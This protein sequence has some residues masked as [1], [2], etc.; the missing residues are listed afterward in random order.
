V[1][2]TPSVE[3]DSAAT[4][5]DQ[6]RAGPYRILTIRAPDIVEQAEPGQFVS[7]AVEAAR[8]LLRRPF[9]IA[10]IDMQRHTFDVVVAVV[11]QGSAWLAS[12]Q[13]SYPLDVVGP[14]GRGFA[15][16]VAPAPC[17][18][19]GGGYGTAALEW[20]GQYLC[21]DGH[22]IELLSGAATASALYPLSWLTPDAPGEGERQR[23]GGRGSS[24]EGERQR[25]GGRGSSGE[26]E[27]QRA[28]GRGF[29]VIET[30]EDGS[31]GSAGLVT[32]ALAERLERRPGAK[33]FACGPMAMLAAVADITR[34]CGCDCQVAVE[35]HMGC[36]VGVCM[37]C[38]VP[39]TEG[40]LRACIDGPVLSAERV[41]WGS[42]RRPNHD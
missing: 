3:R 41:D 4:L 2:T 12:L 14:L 23:A 37:T 29:H 24:G 5:V 7:I 31:R 17:V 36:S 10:G 22:D 9:A 1:I 38:V 39:T 16:P 26:G 40:Y 8:T 27:R 21:R 28:G 15:L 20:L 30:T 6:G 34:R 13:P 25:A 11:G 42:I 35:E 19:V 33:V 32:A 18:L